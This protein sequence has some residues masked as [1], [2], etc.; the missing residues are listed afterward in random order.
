MNSLNKKRYDFIIS[1]FDINFFEYFIEGYYDWDTLQI[2]DID[3][4]L[5][6][7]K[8][9]LTVIERTIIND[10]TSNII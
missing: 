10:Y 9:Y 7:I 5:K 4:F 8:E 2:E 6:I 1:N 3:K